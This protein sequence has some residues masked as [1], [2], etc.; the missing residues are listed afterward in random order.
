MSSNELVERFVARIVG[1][2]F[3][4]H[5]VTS[6][7]TSVYSFLDYL[8]ENAIKLPNVTVDDVETYCVWLATRDRPLGASSINVRLNGL[9]AFFNFAGRLR[10]DMFFLIGVASEVPNR[11]KNRSLPS[12]VDVETI[13]HVVDS[14]DETCLMG[15]R[16]RAFI[17]FCYASGLRVS[18]ACNVLVDDID[19]VDGSVRVRHG[20]G[21]K[22]RVVPISGCVDVLTHYLEKV[23]PEFYPLSHNVFVSSMGR[24]LS[25]QHVSNMLRGRC[26][27]AN[28]VPFTCHQLRHS[29][30]TH[31][32]AGGASLVAL[33]EMLGHANVE[34]TMQYIAVSKREVEKQHELHPLRRLNKLV[35]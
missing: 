20:K 4:D 2:G 28:V 7:K 33:K 1:R 31:L 21:D 9:R 15:A 26:M 17:L 29:F 19:L 27:E 6:Y 10:H 8:S 25:R 24:L 3:S 32:A 14:I 11:K 5:T 16:D 18:E 34:T 13:L 22:D 30:G 35:P 12:P 23:R